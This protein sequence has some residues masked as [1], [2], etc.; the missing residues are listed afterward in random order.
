MIKKFG[1][2]AYTIRE[3]MTNIDELN[4]SFAKLKALGYDELQTASLLTF[5]A[6][7]YARIAGDNGINIIGTH[8]D[9]QKMI[10]DPEAA[11]A[12]HRIL[13]TTNI[14]TGAMPLEARESLDACRKYCEEINEFAA[15]ISK[16][17]F[18]FTYHNHFFE[19]ERRE[20]GKTLMDVLVEELDPSNITFCLDCAWVQCGGADVRYWIE[21]LAGRIDILHLKDV[22]WSKA[23]TKNYLQPTSIGDGHL[24]WKGIVETAE[25]AGVK[26][27]IVE[28]DNNFLDGDP[29]KSLERSAKYIKENL[30]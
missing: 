11:M 12:M 23:N 29:F 21:K 28:Q 14:G 26:H 27:Y 20:G 13:G 8:E 7:E 16:E 2:Q 9:S 22:A 10:A 15:L 4:A 3:H 30:M 17:G 18:K 1:F 25:K 5:T 6:E 19:F 24:F